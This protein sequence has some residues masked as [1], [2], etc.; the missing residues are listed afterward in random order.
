MSN[1]TIFILA[2]IVLVLVIVLFG[3]DLLN[4]LGINSKEQ[5][6]LFPSIA[7]ATNVGG[8]RIR[9]S[10]GTQVQLNKTPNGWEVDGFEG[11]PDIEV[12]VENLVSLKTSSVASK[13]ESNFELFEVTEDKAAHVTLIHSNGTEYTILVGKAGTLPNSF[14]VRRPGE[15]AVYAVSGT[16]RGSIMQDTEGWRNK[17]LLQLGENQVQ[18]IEVENGG[19]SYTITKRDDSSWGLRY[20]GISAIVSDSAR[21]RLFTTL[22]RLEAQG[23]DINA[24]TASIQENPD[25]VIRISGTNTGE[26]YSIWLKKKDTQWQAATSMSEYVY[27]FAEHAFQNIVTDPSSMHSDS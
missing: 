6:R 17:V 25:A 27:V 14:Y 20:G 9:Q 18:T 10:D 3:E 2:G 8:V 19:N 24:T 5:N 12:F 22:L 13:S 1:K 21:N 15:L 7:Q 11:S 26:V 16:I 23:F 4:S